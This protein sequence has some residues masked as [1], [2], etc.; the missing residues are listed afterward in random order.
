M[1]IEDDANVMG[2]AISIE[3]SKQS[4]FVDRIRKRAEAGHS[5]LDA[6]DRTR[7]FD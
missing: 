1:T 4:P 3:K 6:T 7:K 5:H 2:Q